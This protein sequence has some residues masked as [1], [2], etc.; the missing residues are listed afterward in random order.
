MK[1]DLS[2]YSLPNQKFLDIC[3]LQS[4]LMLHWYS[5]VD[6]ELLQLLLP[7]A[8]MMELGK[9]ILANV[10]IE[11]GRKDEF[12]QLIAQSSLEN[13]HQIEIDFFWNCKRG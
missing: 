2:P 1:I 8:F 11:E 3:T 5:K 12:A 10:A 13:I 9:V 4:A 7:A 6:R